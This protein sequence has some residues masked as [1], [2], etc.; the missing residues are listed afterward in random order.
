MQILSNKLN[1]KFSLVLKRK[2][3]IYKINKRNKIDTFS[4]FSFQFY[5]DIIKSQ[6]P[7]ACL[8]NRTTLRFDF[9]PSF[10][11]GISG[12]STAHDAYKYK[13]KRQAKMK[14]DIRKIKFFILEKHK[15]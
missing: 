6:R 5:L 15:P 12:F 14:R 7:Q 8:R 9:L 10:N 13:T 11:P 2:Q 4:S 3:K 1:K